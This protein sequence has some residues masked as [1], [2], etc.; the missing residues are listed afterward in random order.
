MR[1]VIVGGAGFVGCAVVDLLRARGFDVCVADSPTRL[2]R[3]ADLLTGVEQWSFRFGT[4][5]PKSMTPLQGAHVLVHLACTTDPA[6]SMETVAYDA[7][8]NIGPS[9]RLFDAAVAAGVKRVIFASS[10]GTVYGVPEQ[11]PIGESS[12]TRPLS[13]YGVSKLAIE[14][15]LSLYSALDGITLRIA[16]PYGAYQFRGASVG[17]IARYLLAHAR[18]EAVEVWG[19]GRVI[20]DY[21]AIDDVAEAF[22]HAIT[23]ALPA[24]P[25][26]IGSGIGASINDIISII[27]TQTGAPLRARY[28]ESRPYD[29]PAVVLDHSRFARATGWRPR[30]TLDTGIAALWRDARVIAGECTGKLR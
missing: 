12:P 18:G 6:L 3:S 16:N 5:D 22:V 23:S 28:L 10:G 1:V 14:N 29:V 24:G 21:L 26:N 27:G 4:D 8:S 13:A 7:D 17:V 11:L 19:D 2:A 30:V 15:Y 9:I 25:Y 20:R